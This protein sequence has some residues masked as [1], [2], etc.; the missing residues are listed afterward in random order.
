M[1]APRIN[2][3]APGDLLILKRDNTPWKILRFKYAMAYETDF[4]NSKNVLVI[5]KSCTGG[6]KLPK[7]V[8]AGSE[9]KGFRLPTKAEVVLY[10]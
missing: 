4:Q 9:I 7:L 10:G 6:A 2:D 3:V 5:L 1:S 8:E